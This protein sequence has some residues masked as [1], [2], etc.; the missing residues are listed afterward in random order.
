[1]KADPK[2]EAAVMNVMDQLIEA[3]TKRDL[4]AALALFAPDPDLVTIGTGGDEKCIGLAERKAQF[5][6]DFAQAEDVSI[7]LGWH[8]LSAAGLV[9]WVAADAIVHAKASG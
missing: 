9:A 5:E 7:K 3:Y 1:M 4:D 6:R 2:T 8:S